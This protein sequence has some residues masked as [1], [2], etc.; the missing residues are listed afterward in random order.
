MRQDEQLRYRYQ[1]LKQLI[2]T[3]LHPSMP[4]D[5]YDEHGQG[6]ARQIHNEDIVL[7]STLLTE[8][9]DYFTGVHAVLT[10]KYLT[11]CHRLQ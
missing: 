7:D 3:L 5:V 1:Y 6:K 8:A 4:K 10:L 11:T 9:N 2:D